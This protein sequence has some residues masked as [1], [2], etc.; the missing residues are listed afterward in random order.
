MCSELG[1][2]RGWEWDALEEVVWGILVSPPFLNRVFNV[3]LLDRSVG[4]GDGLWL[5]QRLFGEMPGN[6]GP[7]KSWGGEPLAV[8]VVM[9]GLEI[10]N[11]VGT[12]GSVEP[13]LQILWCC[14]QWWLRTADREKERFL[15]VV[16][17]VPVHRRQL[18]L[19]LFKRR[20]RQAAGGRGFYRVLRKKLQARA[21]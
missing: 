10:M 1:R 12:G 15:F 13:P 17:R 11:R 8:P 5:G 9:Q 14:A 19:L 3:C 7:C 4:M 2:L 20:C 18:S 6:E 21:L 16:K